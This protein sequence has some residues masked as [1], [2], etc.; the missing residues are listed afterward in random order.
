[1]PDNDDRPEFT[2]PII[3]V[4]IRP[5]GRPVPQTVFSHPDR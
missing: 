3:G 2:H 4:T 1:M 5:T